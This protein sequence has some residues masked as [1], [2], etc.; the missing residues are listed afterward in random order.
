VW[1]GG[2][3]Y[4]SFYAA[5]S[6][7]VTVAALAELLP[8]IFS[9]CA[10]CPHEVQSAS[11]WI[12]RRVRICSAFSSDAWRLWSNVLWAILAAIAAP[13]PVGRAR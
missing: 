6:V 3:R 10:S 12:L 5:D 8:D 2:G 11:D 1:C 13:V 9:L 7:G 4:H